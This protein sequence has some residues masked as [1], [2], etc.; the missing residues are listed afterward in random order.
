MWLFKIVRTL[1][2]ILSS[3]CKI[4]VVFQPAFYYKKPVDKKPDTQKI[5]PIQRIKNQSEIH[6]GR[7]EQALKEWLKPVKMTVSF[8]WIKNMK[9]FYHASIG[10]I[11]RFH[12]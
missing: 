8:L 12:I 5:G 3:G 9:K 4:P 7:S 6:W 2:W 10:I 11:W 1:H